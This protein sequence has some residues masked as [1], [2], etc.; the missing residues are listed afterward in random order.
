MTQLKPVSREKLIRKLKLFGFEGPF[1]G[2]K[3]LFMIKGNL[4]LTIPNPHR[5]EIGVDLL[6][7]ILKQAGISKEEW[8]NREP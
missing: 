1:P 7:R 5:K 8:I 6:S 3:H 2:G 4:R